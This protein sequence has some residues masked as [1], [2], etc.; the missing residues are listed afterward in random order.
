MGIA[1]SLEGFLLWKHPDL[2]T[3]ALEVSERFFWCIM[4]W[5]EKVRNSY[6]RRGFY[7]WIV[8]L[9]WGQHSPRPIYWSLGQYR[10]AS[11]S[12]DFPWGCALQWELRVVGWAPNIYKQARHLQI[13]TNKQELIREPGSI[14]LQLVWLESAGTETLASWFLSIH[15]F[16]YLF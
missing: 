12:G 1:E 8:Y 9:K 15:L 11:S 16:I 10:T 3:L 4:E 5:K 14:R 2:Q 6:R 7:H 13:F